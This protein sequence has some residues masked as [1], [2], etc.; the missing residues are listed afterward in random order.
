MATTLQQLLAR[1]RAMVFSRRLDQEFDEELSVHLDMAADD[2]V[3]K[4]LTAEQARRAAVLRLG[5]RTSLKDQHRAVRGLPL[6]ETVWRDACLAIRMLVRAPW[7]TATAF[8][9]LALGI[10][11]NTAIFSVYS[12]LLLEPLPYS[13][14]DRLVMILE[15]D[16]EDGDTG[17]VTP[18]DFEDWR[19]AAVPLRICLRSLP[20]RTSTSPWAAS[21]SGCLARPCRR[22]S[23][24][25]SGCASRSAVH[26]AWKR[27]GLGTISW[28]S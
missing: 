19:G 11:A 22:I 21:L 23:S 15:K 28:P 2:Y 17:S 1:V 25:C 24:S 9:T 14:S 8:L 16:L 18:A 3:R 27:N 12:S 5:G 13:D 6:L 4:G 7:F 20:I 26:F 10:A